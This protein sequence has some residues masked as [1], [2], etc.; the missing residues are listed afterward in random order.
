[1]QTKQTVK[2]KPETKKIANKKIIVMDSSK[3]IANKKIIVTDS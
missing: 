1:L 2:K 3:K